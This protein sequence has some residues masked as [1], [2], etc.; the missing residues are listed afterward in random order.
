MMIVEM[1]L[2]DSQGREQRPGFG[3]IVAE[4]AE[5]GALGFFGVS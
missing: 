3:Q 2:G 5:C 4:R 1:G